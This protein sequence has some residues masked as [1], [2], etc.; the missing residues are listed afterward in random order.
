[1]KFRTHNIYTIHTHTQPDPPQYKF[2]VAAKYDY[3]PRTAEDLPLTKGEKFSVLDSS[4]DWWL[5]R[6]Q[7][8]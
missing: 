1:M 2:E 3:S 5:A 6:N 7:Q 4:G 8:G